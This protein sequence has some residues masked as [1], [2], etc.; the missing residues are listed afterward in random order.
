MAVPNL[1]LAD[2]RPNILLVLLDDAGFMDLG[3]RHQS[4]WA[5]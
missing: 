5:S 1:A 3:V 2:E 4:I